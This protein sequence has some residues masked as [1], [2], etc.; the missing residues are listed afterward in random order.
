MT[1]FV[2]DNFLTFTLAILVFFLG[3]HTNRRV[4][5]LRK[6]SIPE[7]VTGG[8]IAALFSLAVYLLVDIEIVYQLE[9]RDILLVY[10][11]TGIGLNAKI[12]DLIQ[13]GR[14]LII[15]LALTLGYIVVQNIVGIVGAL[16]VGQPK[17]VGVLAG[18][19]SLIGG[20][21]TTIAWAPEVISL[22]ISNALEIGIA[23]ATIGLILA[24]LIGGPIA[25][26]LINR[27]NLSSSEKDDVVGVSHH[28]E[29][30]GTIDHL[31][32]MAVFLTLHITIVLGWFLNHAVS[33]LGL[34]LPL[35]VTCLL[36]G[37]F[38][39]NTIPPLFPKIGWPVR[40]KAL[41]VVS[42]FSLGLFLSM[43]LMSM[44]LWTIA[45]LAGPLMVILLMQTLAAIFFILFVLFPLMGR[46]Y[47]AAVLSAGFGGFALGATPTA[48]ANMTAVTKTHGPAPMA[49]IILPLIAAFF[50]DITNS[51]VIKFALS[52]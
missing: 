46:N 11:F 19:T 35:F 16:V 34:K 12:S 51:F 17:A 50:V 4:A 18:S 47:Q 52:L 44:Q 41:A 42:D 28:E 33:S 29:E 6:Y 26:I 39:S 3:V 48:I 2:A 5:F 37:I 49:F 10:F 45:G 21:G 22:G 15:M 38:L 7:P 8:L 14:P 31:N 9:T 30:T 25:Q 27:F 24:S 23:C 40:T 20:H 43:S 1:Q 36:A 13:G 32:L